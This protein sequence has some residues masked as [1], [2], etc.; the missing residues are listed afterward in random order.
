MFV[1]LVLFLASQLNSMQQLIE[2][3]DNDNL[4]EN[5][6]ELISK[7]TRIALNN[8][9]N[10]LARGYLWA[11]NTQ[12][13]DSP[14][15]LSAKALMMADEF[16]SA[17]ENMR[18][19]INH[20][21]LVP[22]Q[23]AI[24]LSKTK[25]LISTPTL[26]KGRSIEEKKLVNDIEK[27]TKNSVESLIKMTIDKGSIHAL[28]ILLK[29]KHKKTLLKTVSRLKQADKINKEDID[30]INR[31]Y[32]KSNTKLIDGELEY[33]L[34][35]Q[36]G[37]N[38]IGVL[39]GNLACALGHEKALQTML[40]AGI[41]IVTN[42]PEFLQDFS[43]YSLYAAMLIADP[44]SILI[45]GIE[46]LNHKEHQEEAI[47]LLEYFLAMP[48][49][50]HDLLDQFVLSQNDNKGHP[51]Y[52]PHAL[53]QFYLDAN[54]PS[55]ALEIFLQAWEKGFIP[56]FSLRDKLASTY[57]DLILSNPSIKLELINNI[58]SKKLIES[59]Q[60]HSFLMSIYSRL[61]STKDS[62]D[63]FLNLLIALE[64]IKNSSLTATKEWIDAQASISFS[65]VLF[66]STQDLYSYE[67]SVLSDLKSLL[68]NLEELV[69]DNFKG[70]YYYSL[71]LISTKINH[72]DESTYLAKA[73][74]AG[75]EFACLLK[76]YQ[77]CLTTLLTTLIKKLSDNIEILGTVQVSKQKQLASSKQK[78]NES[79]KVL[80]KKDIAINNIK[81]FIS[82]WQT[83]HWKTSDRNE[84]IKDFNKMVL[85]NDEILPGH[86]NFI[87]GNHGRRKAKYGNHAS[88]FEIDTLI[89]RSQK[90][91]DSLL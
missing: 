86:S 22:S 41:E 50:H 81:K 67:F 2:Q 19:F 43:Y 23:T 3:I 37:P 18:D 60:L 77:Q 83:I 53:V 49:A 30:F 11:L 76:S 79:S 85:Q 73:A 58:K 51:K 80:S 82:K 65:L 90:F 72:K 14:I 38:I 84:L 52:S 54:N 12:A 75:H 46:N 42:D 47:Q 57:H 91:L 10:M 7:L 33:S 56:K 20:N 24:H 28:E 13:I 78:T 34:A 59:F 4:S 68:E 1:I 88:S 63:S 26:V 15:K 27:I 35:Q 16:N 89:V 9:N 25:K 69:L 71:Y 87:H 6:R 62:M 55:Q 61:D 40:F 21:F 48:E 31:E 5:P 64:S 44:T 70:D 29:N 36:K 74:Q 17:P 32:F 45:A 39:L 8:K 66:N